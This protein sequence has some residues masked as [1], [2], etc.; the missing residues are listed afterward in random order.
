[1]GITRSPYVI[2]PYQGI[3]NY[4]KNIDTEVIY[5]D[6]NNLEKLK[7]AENL[8][9]IIIVVGYTFKDEGEYIMSRVK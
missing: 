4:F 2:T 1:M 5:D 8:D 9:Q 7:I 3:K 6:G